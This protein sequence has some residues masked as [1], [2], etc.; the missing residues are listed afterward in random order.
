MSS[1]YGTSCRD[2]AL[3]VESHYGTPVGEKYGTLLCSGTLRAIALVAR[4][5]YNGRPLAGI[6]IA[7]AGLY[8]WLTLGTHVWKPNREN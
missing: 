6:C 2:Y 5:R 1:A 7:A 3:G 8:S 4:E